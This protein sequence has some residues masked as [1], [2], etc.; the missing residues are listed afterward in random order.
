MK[1]LEQLQEEAKK[2]RNELNS[3]LNDICDW[4]IAERLTDQIIAAAVAKIKY[5]L[6]FA[7]KNK[8][9]PLFFNVKN[10]RY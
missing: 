4:K 2:E 6:A 1:T 9:D 3:M 8:P 5:D 10:G 7:E